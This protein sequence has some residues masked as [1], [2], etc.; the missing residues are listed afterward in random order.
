M[1][2]ALLISSSLIRQERNTAKER[3]V[4]IIVGF[5]NWAEG[6]TIIYLMFLVKS[7]R[8]KVGFILV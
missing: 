7:F 1:K 3:M 5:N 8:N 4:R 2:K 6:F